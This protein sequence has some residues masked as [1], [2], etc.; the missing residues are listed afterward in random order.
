MSPG[1]R[2]QQS[3]R[4]SASIGSLA[5]SCAN[6]VV[7]S[8]TVGSFHNSEDGDPRVDRCGGLPVRM[9]R[10]V[11]ARPKAVLCVWGVLFAAGCW[12]AP[13]LL[14]QVRVDYEPVP[15]MP[16]YE[17]KRSL[18][19]HFPG[20]LDEVVDSV[21]F[22]FSSEVSMWDRDPLLVSASSGLDKFL[23]GIK[24]AH[25]G[26]IADVRGWRQGDAVTEVTS[27]FAAKDE[28]TYLLQVTWNTSSSQ[29]QA[30]RLATRE[31]LA[32]VQEL[33]Q[34]YAAKGL[35]VQA[36]GTHALTA[37]AQAQARKDIGVHAVM[38]LPLALFVMH[39]QLQS[40]E[41]L[42]LPAL[43]SIVAVV[44]AFAMGAVIARHHVLDTNVPTLIAFLGVSL[45]I[46]WTFF[47]LARIREEEQ[48]HNASLNTAI[49]IALSR[50]GTNVALSG[51]LIVVCSACM[52]IMPPAIASNSIGG[53]VTVCSSLA[54]CLT[55]LPACVAAFP[56]LFADRHGLRFSCAPGSG[57]EW[58]ALM[59]QPGE[60]GEQASSR[61]SRGSG[62]AMT[63]QRVWY[64]WACLVTRFPFNVATL[65][66][67]CVVSAPASFKLWFYVPVVNDSLY[68]PPDAPAVL[69]QQRLNRDFSGSEYDR[70]RL[71]LLVEVPDSCAEGVQ[72]DGYFA[73][74][75]AAAHALLGS[76]GQGGSELQ[77]ADVR[78]MAFYTPPKTDECRCIPWRQNFQ[79]LEEANAGLGG[80]FTPSGHLLLTG[81]TR[82]FVMLPGD[83]FQYYHNLY[84]Q[85]WS[86]L[87]SADGRASVMVV[88]PP[89]S[90]V[91]WPTFQLVDELR[92]LRPALWEASNDSCAHVQSWELS[93]AGIW[94]DYI[95]AS[96]GRLPWAIGLAC[97]VTTPF[98]AFS[99]YSALAPLK[100][101]LTVVAPMTWV[102]GTAI[103]VFQ[104]AYPG[105]FSAPAPAGPADGQ[106][107]QGGLHWMVPC[108]SSMLLL[109]LALDYNVFYFGRALEFRKAGLSDLESVRQGLASTGPV[110]TCAGVIFALEFA[111]LL[112]SETALNRQGGFVVVVGILMDTFI[113]R[114]CLMPAVLSLGASWNWW[115]AVMPPVADDDE[116]SSVLGGK[117]SPSQVSR[118]SEDDDEVWADPE[119]L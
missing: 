6:S 49:V 25:P 20:L 108:S 102:Y 71:Y 76:P 21:L 104:D 39:T 72:S 113:V 55:L 41:L 22:C 17:A 40:L 66:L 31:L 11:V 91:S 83:L 35:E 107:E 7:S 114:S 97:L 18:D 46:D 86:K 105:P 109:S 16:S 13:G 64:L 60:E 101:L 27:S 15:G 117:K 10:A 33:S 67:F 4:R 116:L 8:S 111:G 37:A 84:R 30:V 53:L 112:M 57:G 99:F 44:C 9:A 12:M 115:P 92:N 89:Q 96:T 94:Y 14:D 61:G 103:W 32:K 38:F 56:T 5:E 98:V 52:V 95:M 26:I 48:L 88:M 2:P 110:I 77:A 34:E 93:K 1:S 74:L 36:T 59:V 45:C 118:M 54:V 69:A 87:V 79:S 62:S 85:M 58:D 63:S 75:C 23:V 51:M 100:L 90:G 19:R 43:C 65:V 29:Q 78:G 3:Y 81:Q 42:P 70:S 82:H 119:G 68:L 24:E 28:L 106:R 80:N 73:S 47:L 50:T